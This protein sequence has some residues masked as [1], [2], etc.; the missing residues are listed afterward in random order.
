MTA[1][2]GDDRTNT[3]GSC[4]STRGRSSIGITSTVGGTSALRGA[5]NSWTAVQAW[6][7]AREI[8]RTGSFLCNFIVGLVSV[9]SRQV[10]DSRRND[11]RRL[12]RILRWLACWFGQGL[13]YL[14]DFPSE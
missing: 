12:T 14:K 8:S 10:G 4:G 9:L 6:R 7:P 11:R 3:L 13:D 1:C 5:R 2:S